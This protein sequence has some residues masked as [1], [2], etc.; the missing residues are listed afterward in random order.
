[1]LVS[2]KD[3]LTEDD[4]RRV[5]GVP[6]GSQNGLTKQMKVLNDA[7]IYYWLKN[8]GTIGTTWHHVHNARP[9]TAHNDDS[10]PN[11]SATR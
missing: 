11:F 7:G 2:P 6:K 5:T 10:L 4:I 8:D 1:M 3:D 9:R